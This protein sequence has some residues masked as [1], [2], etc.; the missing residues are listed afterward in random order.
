[1]WPNLGHVLSKEQSQNLQ[2]PSAQCVAN[3][4]FNSAHFIFPDAM[5]SS[6]R[7]DDDALIQQIVTPILLEL[8]YDRNLIQQ[9]FRVVGNARSPDIEE[10]AR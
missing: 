5:Q 7:S 1:M 4:S 3:I 6:R 10:M 9:F 8:K 2:E